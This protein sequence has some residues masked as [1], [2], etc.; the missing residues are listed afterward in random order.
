MLRLPSSCRAGYR[1]C[2]TGLRSS[3]SAAG[4]RR[5]RRGARV[6]CGCWPRSGG[7]CA[8]PTRATRSTSSSPR[9]AI[10]GLHPG[11]R[12]VWLQY[13]AP[14]RPSVP[15]RRSGGFYGGGMP[16]PQKRPPTLWSLRRARPLWL[17][18]AAPATSPTARVMEVRGEPLCRLDRGSATLPRLVPRRRLDFRV[19][20]SS[21]FRLPDSQPP[22]PLM[23]C[24][25]PCRHRSAGLRALPCQLCQTY[26][27]K[28]LTQGATPAP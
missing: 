23:H 13:V 10:K 3:R 2:R 22:R 20:R 28:T 1:G 18:A 24:L 9:T 12:S 8:R 21:R 16:S 27:M 25:A 7:P 19:L 15:A 11:S 26:R 14:H 4:L 17:A 5:A 6:S